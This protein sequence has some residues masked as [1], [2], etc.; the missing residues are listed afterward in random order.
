M[1]VCEMAEMNLTENGIDKEFCPG[2]EKPRGITWL[3]RATLRCKDY[4]YRK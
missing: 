2:D 3:H 1:G 4:E